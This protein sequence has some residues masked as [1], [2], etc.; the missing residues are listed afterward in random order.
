M[1]V[2][3]LCAELGATVEELEED[4][5]IIYLSQFMRLRD[6]AELPVRSDRSAATWA[7]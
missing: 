3:A 7:I 5:G 2:P 4:T 1:D 6:R